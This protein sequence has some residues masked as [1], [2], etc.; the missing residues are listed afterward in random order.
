MS[1][2]KFMDN[3]MDSSVINQLKSD[4]NKHL[5]KEAISKDDEYQNVQVPKSLCIKLQE[6]KI[7]NRKTIKEQVSEAINDYI[8]N[9][10]LKN[11]M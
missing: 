6:I 8:V 1:K 7:Y 9:Q 10:S 5:K 11:P 3:L 2:N 4:S